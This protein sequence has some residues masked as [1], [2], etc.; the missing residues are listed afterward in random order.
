MKLGMYVMYDKIDKVYNT[1]TINFSR[2]ERELCRAYLQQ[3]E[4]DRKVNPAEYSLLK[5]GTFDDETCKFDLLPTPHEVDINQIY[6]PAK[7]E[8]GEVVDE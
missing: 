2:S 5:L 7:S 4:Q 3:F 8:N 1:R 6:A